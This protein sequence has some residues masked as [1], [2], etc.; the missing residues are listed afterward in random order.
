[1][2]YTVIDLYALLFSLLLN[3]ITLVMLVLF[4]FLSLSVILVCRELSLLSTASW[5]ILSIFREYNWFRRTVISPGAIFNAASFILW[6]SSSFLALTTTRPACLPACTATHRNLSSFVLSSFLIAFCS[7]PEETFPWS[8][9]CVQTVLNV[10]IRVSLCAEDSIQLMGEETG[11]ALK[12]LI[13]EMLITA[14]YDSW[15]LTILSWTLMFSVHRISVCSDTAFLDSSWN[16]V[17]V[18][19]RSVTFFCSSFIIDESSQSSLSSLIS[20]YMV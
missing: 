2:K 13:G 20:S 19:L 7:A 5:L 6:S 10:Q 14:A 8:W 17:C 4:S 9:S 15:V 11:R 12:W 3:Y 16:W 18:T 1:M